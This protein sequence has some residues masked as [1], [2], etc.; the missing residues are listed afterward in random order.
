MN[1][2]KSL[3]K[4]VI[5]VV[6]LPLDAVADLVTLGGVLSDDQE[7]YTIKRLGQIKDNLDDAVAP[8]RE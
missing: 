6:V 1:I 3:S 8:D 7:S 5:G 4:A 2:I